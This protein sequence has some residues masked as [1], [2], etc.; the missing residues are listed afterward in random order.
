MQKLKMPLLWV[1]FVAVGFFSCSDD[2]DLSKNITKNNVV[3]GEEEIID[4][5]FYKVGHNKIQLSPE[6]YWLTQ[7]RV[8]EY[9][10][11]D[12]MAIYCVTKPAQSLPTGAKVI[13]H[14][15]GDVQ[16][17][18]FVYDPQIYGRVQVFLNITESIAYISPVYL[19]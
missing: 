16:D 5:A 4:V 15:T 18:N 3:P 2:L 19:S 7:Q 13:S 9:S 12:T 8:D 17:I 6:Q 10:V 1:I 14:K 11:G